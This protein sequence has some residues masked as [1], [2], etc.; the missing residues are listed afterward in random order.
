[1]LKQV[2]ILIILAILF[3]NIGCV[4][5]KFTNI[6]DCEHIKSELK[7]D[8]CFANLMGDVPLNNTELRVK[9]CDK[10][11]NTE[12]RDMCIFEVARDGWRSMPFG[13]LIDLCNNLSSNPLRESCNSINTRPHLQAIR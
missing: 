5:R 7:K 2:R 1:M 4:E 3:L 10:I 9:I 6:S 11:V 12:I 8:R 13:I